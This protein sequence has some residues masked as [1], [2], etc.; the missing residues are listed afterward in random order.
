MANYIVRR[1]LILPLVLFGLSIII[2]GMLMLL[3]PVERAALS[4]TSVPNNPVAIQ[5]IIK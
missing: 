3:S 1:L 4:V 5:E 2:F